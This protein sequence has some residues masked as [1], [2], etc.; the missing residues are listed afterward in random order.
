MNQRI[1]I[2]NT[3]EEPPA[4]RPYL[5]IFVVVGG[6]I[7]LLITTGFR[8][9]A[10]N[11]TWS[12]KMAVG[13]TR[14]VKI[15]AP[16]GKILDRNGVVLADN[17]PSY[18][19]ALYLLEFDSGRDVKKLTKGVRK[20]IE[21][22]RRRM[23]LSVRVNDEVI[24][25]HY[26][27][28]GPL[29]LT[30][31]NDLS[32][33]ALAAFQER[34]PWHKGIDLQIEPVRVYPYKNL[35]SHILGHV[36]KP[37][38]TQEE[39]NIDFDTLG[40]R[41]FSQPTFVGKSGIEKG[42]DSVL[43]GTPGFKEIH[44]SAAGLVEKE[45]L[46]AQPTPGDNVILTLDHDI[47]TIVEEAF[48]GYRG[49][50]VVVDPRNGDVLAMASAPSYDPNLFVPFIRKKDWQNLI[51]DPENPLLNRAI[52]GSYSPGSTFKVI[53]ALAGLK[54]GVI[55][56]T[57]SA[58]CAGRYYLGPIEFKCWQLGGHGDVDLRQAITISCNVY[59]YNLGS[60]LGGPR[61][62][63]MG[64]AF[65]LGQK[66]GIPLDFESSGILPNEEWKRSKNANDRW[67]TGDSVNMAIGQGALNVTPLQ[68]AMVSAALANS[69]T[70]YQPRLILRTESAISPSDGNHHS[71][72]RTMD[73]KE[74]AIVEFLP[75]PI[76]TVPV[77]AEDMKF[78]REAM[79]NVVVEGT[80]K[81]AAQEKIQVAGKTGSAQFKVRNPET[82]E[83]VKQTRAWMISFA[84]YQEPR[85]AIALIAEGGESGGH[86]AA[87]MVGAIYKR[88][89]QLEEDRKKPTPPPSIA[90][91]P[92]TGTVSGSEGEIS[93]DFAEVPQTDF[94]I[95]VVQEEEGV[96]ELPPI[97]IN[98]ERMRNLRSR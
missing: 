97:N 78:V 54:G 21:E 46:R 44:F 13:S 15:P 40:R 80:G 91:I 43:Q 53:G 1:N 95:P 6:L 4:W 50:C 98:L 52:Q 33:A 71:L 32:P 23:Q 8:Q 47:Q 5:F 10:Q 83:L 51:R 85:Y 36:G 58:E 29:P 96:E 64:D 12:D 90:A 75:K 88:L 49:A 9:L 7:T 72:D 31:W 73:E 25:R 61:L 94:P 38:Q 20:S 70:L 45:N 60:K 34:S 19:V 67:T 77:S 11:A 66:T 37:E 2:L 63:E 41:V 22:L 84:P 62:W 30:V 18:N 35:C 56:P 82:G 79:L 86:T 3:P 55:A 87:P 76:S 39:E 28:K 81:N 42:F 26:D 65:G 48:T 16:R 93:G 17:R 57:T 27:Q 74:N 92:I 89:F 68:M 24:R 69:G 59:F 14:A